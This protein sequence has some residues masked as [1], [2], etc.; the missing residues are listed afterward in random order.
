MEARA[1][2]FGHPIHQ[3]LIVLPLGLLTGAVLFDA[4]ALIL[5]GDEWRIVAYWLIPA[6]VLTGLL[7]AVF[8]TADWV[9][10]PRGTR[11]KRVGFVHGF[12][13]VVVVALF[14]L[15]WL[16]RGDSTATPAATAYILSFA[17][18]GLSMITGWLGGELVNRLGVGIDDGAHLDAPSSL[19]GGPAS[20]V[21]PGNPRRA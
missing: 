3:M 9:G 19:S 13:N 8:G 5:G 11:A 16:L 20:N 4:L 12:G 7:A 2:L 18:G 15:S 21:V 6:G 10:I 14:T 1:K 17:G